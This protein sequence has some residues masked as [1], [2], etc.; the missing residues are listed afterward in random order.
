MRASVALVVA[1]ACG[2]LDFTPR[3]DPCP[4]PASAPDPLT[5]SG[6]VIAYRTFTIYDGVGGVTV[7]AFD[8]TTDEPLGSARSAGTGQGSDGDTTTGLYSLAISGG[9]PRRVRLELTSPQWDTTEA[10][11][12]VLGSDL[13]GYLTAVWS[14]GSLGS[15]YGA[16]GLTLPADPSADPYGNLDITVD[17]CDG[18]G[19]A[20]ALVS[21]DPDPTLD[22]ID[23]TVGGSNVTERGQLT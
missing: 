22:E 9:I 1:A 6:R 18:L 16:V 4:V 17:T 21:V 23:V 7:T 12:D 13:D 14:W 20:G 15:V 8:A 10:Y 2:R 11:T 19:I 3:I 5:I